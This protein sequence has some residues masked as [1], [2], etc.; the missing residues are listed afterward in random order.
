M[1]EQT[2]LDLGVDKEPKPSKP[3]RGPQP[4][5]L[6]HDPIEEM[7]GA[8]T[9]PLIVFPSG[10]ED[11]MPEKLKRDLPL[12]RLIHVHQCLSG[13]AEWDEACDLEALMY[14]YPA[15]LAFPM[16]ERWSRIYLYLG[17]RCYG[18]S[19]PEDIKQE[20]LDQYDMAELKGLKRWIQAQKVKARKARR[21]QDKG[22][23]KSGEEPV[24]QLSIPWER[25]K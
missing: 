21:Q 20:T 19:F 22:Q 6:P 9:D 23:E 13:K 12:H 25:L 24:Q 16:G 4:S 10:W 17:T 8:L 2:A 18:T 11:T 5:K 3:P 14:L 15:S 7:L 1:A